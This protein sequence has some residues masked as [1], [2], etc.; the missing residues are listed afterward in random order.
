VP[1]NE[2]DL[3][4]KRCPRCNSS[5]LNE[6]GDCSNADCPL[7]GGPEMYDQGEDEPPLREGLPEFNGAFNRW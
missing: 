1:K 6:N 7:W 4:G 2:V 5:V 3:A